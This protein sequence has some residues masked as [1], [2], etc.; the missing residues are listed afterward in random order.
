MV[1]IKAL[2]A[3]W[4]RLILPPSAPANESGP[5]PLWSACEWTA[6]TPP[7]AVGGDHVLPAKHASGIV[8]YDIDLCWTEGHSGPRMCRSLVLAPLSQVARPETCLAT[9]RRLLADAR[10]TGVAAALQWHGDGVVKVWLFTEPLPLTSLERTARGL[11]EEAMDS[12][13][14]AGWQ[15]ETRALLA[16][17]WNP[18]SASWA[19][20]FADDETPTEINGEVVPDGLLAHQVSLLETLQPTPAMQVHHP[21]G[22]PQ[23][24]SA[25][26]APAQAPGGAPALAVSVLPGAANGIVVV[27]DSGA[28]P[29][30]SI[31]LTPLQALDL[32][33][34]LLRTARVALTAATPPQPP[35]QA[36][37]PPF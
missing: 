18:A 36:E 9:A 10:A 31:A 35:P 37:G 33:Q 7:V 4:R 13:S 21:T 15:I 16:P 26:S 19:Y 3:A 29:T 24:I 34:D 22:A 30:M 17:G 20:F 12:S 5:M 14:V 28:T 8:S 6:M 32:A 25:G 11:I 2:T 23:P 1:S 27:V